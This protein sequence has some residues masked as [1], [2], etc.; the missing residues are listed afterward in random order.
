L[1]DGRLLIGQCGHKDRDRFRSLASDEEKRCLADIHGGV[2][3][4]DLHCRREFGGWLCIP[5]ALH[6]GCPYGIVP[7]LESGNQRLD[8]LIAGAGKNV[9]HRE[10]IV[11]VRVFYQGRQG[12]GNGVCLV[13]MELQQREEHPP[14]VDVG[15]L[16]PLGQG[17]NRVSTNGPKCRGGGD[18][19]GNVL[20]LDGLDEVRRRGSRLDAEFG[21]RLCPLEANSGI[22]VH[23]VLARFCDFLIV[24]GK[25]RARQQEEHG[26]EAC[27]KQAVHGNLL[28]KEQDNRWE[29]ASSTVIM[30]MRKRK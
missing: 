28:K 14:D 21:Q 19:D 24:L 20:L 25:G 1:P 4:G 15:I 5:Q 7:V 16:Q 26:G 12:S 6:H 10:A 18:S 13:R 3:A 27:R 11:Y 9:D 30:N 22:P 2:L 23:Q 17:W 8:T 29:T